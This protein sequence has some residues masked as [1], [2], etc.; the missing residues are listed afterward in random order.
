[1]SRTLLSLACLVALLAAAAPTFGQEKP[2]YNQVTY[3]KGQEASLLAVLKTDAPQKD[4]ADAC[5]LLAIVGTKNAVAP[6]AALLDDEKLA[7]MARYG[8]ES[9]P[10]PSVNVALREALGKV[11][12]LHLA[13]VIGSLGVRKDAQ[14]VAPISKLLKN[15]DCVVKQAAA[16]SLGKIGTPEAAGAIGAA[17]PGVD[18]CCRLSF[19]E[20]L[21][22]AAECLAAHGKKDAAL[23]ICE[24]LTKEPAPAQVRLGASKK[25]RILRQEPGKGL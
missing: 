16:R 21:L 5:R 18:D 24:T 3:A 7:H 19:C 13:G 4:K 9:N 2:D 1:M 11:K 25:A 20:G 17:L 15:Q 12:G 23:A 6:L 22:R 8:L 10:D 14:A